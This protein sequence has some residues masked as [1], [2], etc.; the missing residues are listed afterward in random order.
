MAGEKY[1]SAEEKANPVY[2][3]PTFILTNMGYQ[4]QAPV[5]FFFYN[6][7]F[8]L[9]AYYLFTVFFVVNRFFQV[10]IFPDIP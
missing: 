5:L 6:C 4:D 8:F 1:F 3:P 9:Q 10:N 2:D 7:S